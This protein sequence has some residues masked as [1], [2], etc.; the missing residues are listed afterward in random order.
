L[1]QRPLS[2]LLT[3]LFNQPRNLFPPTEILVP[4]QIQQIHDASMHILESV[5]LDFLD[6]KAL[7][8]WHKVGT[9][10]ENFIKLTSVT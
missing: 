5:G 8:I 10:A 3:I 1:S 6:V 7:P 9:R 2:L 4:N